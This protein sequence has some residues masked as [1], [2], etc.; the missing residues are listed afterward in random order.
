MARG[1]KKL[2]LWTSISVY[3]ERIN[4]RELE[5]KCQTLEDRNLSFDHNVRYNGSI[6]FRYASRL[7]DFRLS[8]GNRKMQLFALSYINKKCKFALDTPSNRYSRGRVV[9]KNENS[10][11]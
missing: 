8:W 7:M 5:I 4:S 6:P 2:K 9:I 10:D 11:A 3:L 1:I